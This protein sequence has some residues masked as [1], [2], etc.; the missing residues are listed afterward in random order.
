VDVKLAGVPSS[1]APAKDEDSLPTSS[2]PH[3]R[4]PD[5]LALA[6]PVLNF[7]LSPS[8]SRV[9]MVWSSSCIDEMSRLRM[10][11]VAF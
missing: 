1:P 11:P 5:A 2:A 3:E 7:C 4:L 9:R 8:P 10:A 6:Y